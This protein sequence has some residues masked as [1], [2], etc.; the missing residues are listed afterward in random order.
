MANPNLQELPQMRTPKERA[1]EELSE[2]GL[3]IS[4]VTA[5]KLYKG[6]ANRRQ[7]L[8]RLRELAQMI[9][10]YGEKW[11]DAPSPA[12]QQVTRRMTVEETTRPLESGLDM[13]KLE[14]AMYGGAG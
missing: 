9:A 12:P 2:H 3:W 4:D 11:P 6:K 10:D 14:S 1:E 5:S 8:L 13:R 7:I